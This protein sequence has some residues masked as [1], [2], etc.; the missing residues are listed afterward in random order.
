MPDVGLSINQGPGSEV[1]T[2]IL[3]LLRTEGQQSNLR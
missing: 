3:E 2:I 1:G